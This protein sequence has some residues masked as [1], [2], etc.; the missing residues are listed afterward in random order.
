MESNEQNKL[1]NKIEPQALKH[2]EDWKWPEGRGRKGDNQR[3]KGEGLDKEPAWVTHGH[4]QCPSV[5]MDCGSR[6]GMGRGWQKGKHW[7]NCNRI[8]I[9]IDFKKCKSNVYFVSHTKPQVFNVLG[10]F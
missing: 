7:D 8:T 1:T 4:G 5:G 6:G 10:I 2:G 9:K 3:E